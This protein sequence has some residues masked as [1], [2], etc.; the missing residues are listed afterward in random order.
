MEHTKEL[1]LAAHEGKKEARDTLVSENMGLVKKIALKYSSYGNEYDDMVQIGVIGLIK[2]IDR[3]D[4]TAD[5][6]F[7]TYAV[8]MIIGEIKRFLR[9]DGM[10]KISRILKENNYK[11]SAAESAFMAKNAREATIDELS[12]ITGISCEDIVMS[13][14]ACMQVKSIY[15]P[16]GSEDD[17]TCMIDMIAQRS[18]GQDETAAV[19]DKM[20][21]KDMLLLMDERERKLIMLR[22]FED[23]TQSETASL[24]GMTQVQVSRLEKKVL[25]QMKKKLTER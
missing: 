18:D 8:P 16:V 25:A 5:V 11:I 15:Q 6:M 24:L 2:C 17:G 20:V 19:I 14:E 12:T 1:L 9:D 4:V 21:L 7:S 22:Y 23:K 10:I 3:F 13:R